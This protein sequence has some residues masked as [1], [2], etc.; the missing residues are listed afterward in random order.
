MYVSEVDEQATNNT[1]H[2]VRYVL[3]QPWP[4]G[5]P[6]GRGRCRV[7][8]GIDRMFHEHWQGWTSLGRWSQEDCS[9][10]TLTRRTNVRHG[11]QPWTVWLRS[12]ERH[13]VILF[14]YFIHLFNTVWQRTASMTNMSMNNEHKVTV[15]AVTDSLRH[16]ANASQVAHATASL[17]FRRLP[18]RGFLLVFCSNHSPKCTVVEQRVWTDRQTDRQTDRRTFFEALLNASY[19]RGDLIHDLLFLPISTIESS[20]S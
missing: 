15:Y 12:P 16:L 4:E 11:R 6:V 5:D 7:R 19:R 8:G 1:A 10:G 20:V 17:P 9:L 18:A 3:M 13:Q 2:G 14:I